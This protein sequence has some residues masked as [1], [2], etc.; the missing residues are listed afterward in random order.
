[1]S[2]ER[3][4]EVTAITKLPRE[5]KIPFR[6]KDARVQMEVFRDMAKLKVD[7]LSVFTEINKANVQAARKAV[8]AANSALKEPDTYRLS[9]LA[10]FRDANQEL[11]DNHKEWVKPLKKEV[12]S[13]DNKVKAFLQYQQSGVTEEKREALATLGQVNGIMDELLKFVE[14]NLST[15]AGKV[16]SKVEIDNTFEIE[17]GNQAEAI[18]DPELKAEVNALITETCSRINEVNKIRN[19]ILDT[20]EISTQLN[21]LIHSQKETDSLKEFFLTTFEQVQGYL[22]PIEKQAGQKARVTGLRKKVNVNI[23]DAYKLPKDI[24]TD[25]TVVEALQKATLAYFK[26]TGEE[27]EG[28]KIWESFE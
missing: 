3:A 5:L 24:M 27:P 19:E 6:W 4:N 9:I 22:K 14:T 11:I 15:F 12:D 2:N 23:L 28:T 10:P 13:L 8:K 7:A 18:S 25:P 16:E 21:S 1:M 20:D 17:L 26:E